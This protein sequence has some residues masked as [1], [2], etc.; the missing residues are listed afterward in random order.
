MYYMIPPLSRV[1]RYWRIPQVFPDESPL[2][3]RLQ[4]LDPQCVS[5]RSILQDYGECSIY[6]GS[7]QR[8]SDL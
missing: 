7:N 1:H 5:L 4:S 8:P 2:A 6:S 3:V